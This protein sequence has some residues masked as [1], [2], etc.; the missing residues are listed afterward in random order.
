VSDAGLDAS[1]VRRRILVHG[2]VEGVGF[3]ASCARR[4]LS[5][6][7]GGWVRKRAD[8]AVEAV[9]EGEEEKVA[10]LVAWCS[11]GPPLA[12][13]HDVDVTDEQPTGERSFS[14]R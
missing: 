2:R 1:S 8:G 11:A 9:F 5:V 13:V 10:Q 4:A 6:G 3:R 12:A 14:V 7:V